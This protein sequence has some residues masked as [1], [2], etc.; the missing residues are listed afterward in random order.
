MGY[1][2]LAL[3][4]SVM[5]STVMRLS[6]RFVRNEM[7]MF[8]GN[9][10]TC[11]VLALSFLRKLPS[12]AGEGGLFALLLGM[13]NGAFYLWGFVL[14]RVNMQENGLVLPSTFMK[15]G[16]V[17]VP[18]ILAVTVLGEQAS[19]MQLIGIALAVGAIL[20]MREKEN[21]RGGKKSLLLLLLLVSG[22]GDAASN[23]YDKL[24]ASTRKDDFLTF[25]FLTAGLCA[26]VLLMRKGERFYAKDLLFGVLIG[27]PNYFS[28]RFFLSCLST[29]PALIAYP[30]NSVGSILVVTLIGVFFFHEKLTERKWVALGLIALSLILLNL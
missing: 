11:L 26:L 23:L 4:C 22:I 8:L 29:V 14:L 17:L 6:G 15:L 30:V 13:V 16:I 19:W 27:I 28:A 24:G 1:L 5:I 9:Y 21:R 3:G 10:A 12:A 18:T 25:L 7:A 2:L 20:V